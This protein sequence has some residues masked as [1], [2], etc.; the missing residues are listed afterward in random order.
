MSIDVTDNDDG[1]VIKLCEI[2]SANRD[3]QLNK[4]EINQDQYLLD[5]S[6][7]DEANSETAIEDEEK[8]KSIENSREE[9]L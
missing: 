7:D 9:E 4:A 8:E 5:I 2:V 3:E 1:S 6:E